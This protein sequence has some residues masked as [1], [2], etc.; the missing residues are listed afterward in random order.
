M[1][2][3]DIKLIFNEYTL[4]YHFISVI[5]QHGYNV[6]QIHMRKT[7]KSMKQIAFSN[8]KVK[9]DWWDWK[10]MTRNYLLVL[11]ICFYLSDNIMRKMIWHWWCNLDDVSTCNKLSFYTILQNEWIALL[12]FYLI[13]YY[14]KTNTGV[15]IVPSCIYSFIWDE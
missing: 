10:S 15:E 13:L 3:W 11:I 6:L 7:N 8:D 4:L 12:K 9:M 2:V 1:N 14:Q 5:P